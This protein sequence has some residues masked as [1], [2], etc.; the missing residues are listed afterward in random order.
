M[1]R[2]YSWQSSTRLFLQLSCKYMQFMK[3]SAGL[4]PLF[5]AVAC[6]TPEIKNDL[7]VQLNGEAPDHLVVKSS[8]EVDTL[9][10]GAEAQYEFSNSGTENYLSINS[11][12]VRRMIYLEKGKTAT[13]VLTATNVTEPL[14][15][16]GELKNENDALGALIELD[17]VYN[18][19]LREALQQDWDG[20]L[21]G[22]KAYLA[23]RDS[24][25]KAMP[26]T[27][28]FADME[29]K[30]NEVLMQSGAFLHYNYHPQL[31]A[32]AQP[33]PQACI[34][35]IESVGFDD[36]SLMNVPEYMDVAQDKL[37]YNL[38]DVDFETSADV[39]KAKLSM[40]EK[41]ENETIK[42]ALQ[43][44]ALEDHI[45][46]SGVD[47]IADNLSVFYAN[48]DAKSKESVQKLAEPWMKIASGNDAPELVMKDAEGTEVTL[49]SFKGKAVYID[50]WATW[51]KPCLA[52]IPAL[53]EL[54]KELKDENIAFLSISVD[55]N[56][57]D[58]NNFL[59]NNDAHGVQLHQGDSDGLVKSE[60]L[61]YSIPRFVLL[62]EEGKIVNANAPRPSGDALAYIKEN[63]LA[64]K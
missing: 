37:E 52:E 53:E 5:F 15:F 61:V 48:A 16:T 45:R 6:T 63:A 22:H 30:R 55:K 56:L 7:I 4:L 18:K 58:W 24:V 41:I 57:E 31:V 46:Y 33:S 38:G 44:S 34:D 3:L 47:E 10:L 20:F 17:K 62:N 51:C 64:K 14:A 27:E 42:I 1:K 12:G 9:A 40:T 11:P 32:D 19:G 2:L 49:S 36:A 23:Q 39:V 43:R 54:Q 35:I 28:K 8:V 26:V 50:F 59:A 29:A 60:Y 21:A 25:V 13:A